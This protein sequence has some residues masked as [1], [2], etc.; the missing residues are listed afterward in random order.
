MRLSRGTGTGESP[1]KKKTSHGPMTI[2]T[3]DLPGMK[4]APLEA[5]NIVPLVYVWPLDQTQTT[6]GI[7][8]TGTRDIQGPIHRPN[9][10]GCGC[11]L[12]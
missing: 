7:A 3:E 9:F 1:P 10:C 2:V 11:R 6:A 12:T 5:R 4:V 8:G